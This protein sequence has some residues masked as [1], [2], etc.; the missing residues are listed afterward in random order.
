MILAW[1][2]AED[3]GAKKRIQK[4]LADRDET[5]GDIKTILQGQ[6]DPLVCS[7]YTNRP[8][9][10]LEGMDANADGVDTTLKDMLGT[11]IGFL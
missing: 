9:E 8:T 3:D 11:L 2:V 4:V 10:Q 5:L 1:L 6:C 7:G